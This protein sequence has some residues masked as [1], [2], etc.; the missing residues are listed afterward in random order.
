MRLPH[1]AA[2]VTLSLAPACYNLGPRTVVHDRFNYQESLSRSGM[3]QLLLNIVKVRYHEAP[4][5]LEVGQIVSGYSLEGQLSA[6]GR[7]D[8]SSDGN[9]VR[10]AELLGISR[11]TLYDLMNRLQIK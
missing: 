6:G 1:L 9:I 4:V 3:E 5:F 11:P 10:A 8:L 7:V 2:I